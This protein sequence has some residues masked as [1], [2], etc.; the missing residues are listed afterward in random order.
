MDACDSLQFG[1]NM[2]KRAHAHECRRPASIAAAKKT[3]AH[4]L[5]RTRSRLK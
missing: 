5:L 2:L 4:N 1:K 3:L